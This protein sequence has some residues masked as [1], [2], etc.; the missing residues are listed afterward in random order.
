MLFPRVC[1]N[2]EQQAN[3]RNESKQVGMGNKS[4]PQSPQVSVLFSLKGL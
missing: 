2:L 3:P 1:S 4:W